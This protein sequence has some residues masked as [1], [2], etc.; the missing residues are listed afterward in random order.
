LKAVF[1]S[2]SEPCSALTGGLHGPNCLATK[3]VVVIAALAPSAIA[4][5]PVPRHGIPIFFTR[6]CPLP[7]S[8]AGP[9]RPGES[10]LWRCGVSRGVKRA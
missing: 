6:I 10:R 8:S 1:S 3:A 5:L 9:L 4:N 7:L 2:G